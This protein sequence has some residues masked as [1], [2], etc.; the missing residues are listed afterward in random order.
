MYGS[1]ISFLLRMFAAQVTKI[2]HMQIM[3]TSKPNLEKYVKPTC[4]KNY[5]DIVL[6]NDGWRRLH[7]TD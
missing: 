2:V 4:K 7:E 6:G 5:F 3:P 1:V